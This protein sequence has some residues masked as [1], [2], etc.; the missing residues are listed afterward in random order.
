MVAKRRMTLY[1]VRQH[2]NLVKLFEY[3][4]K[5]YFNFFCFF[6]GVRA[7]ARTPVVFVRFFVLLL[8]LLPRD[9]PVTKT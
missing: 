3:S 7:N 1:F 9:C 5:T 2:E 4:A 6:L 8:F